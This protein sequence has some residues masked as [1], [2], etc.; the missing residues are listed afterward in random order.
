MKYES[1]QKFLLWEGSGSSVSLQCSGDSKNATWTVL[2]EDVGDGR[3]VERFRVS[4]ILQR[5]DKINHNGRIYPKAILEREVRNYQRLVKERR[6]VG[7][8]VDPK[9]EVFTEHGWKKI[10]LV[11]VGEKVWTIN[12]ETKEKELQEVEIVTEKDF[13]GEMIR[14]RSFMLDMM[15][16]PGHK[17]IYQVDNSPDLT[18]ET[19]ENFYN[20]FNSK[21]LYQF[22]MTGSPLDRGYT[23]K[24]C[25]CPNVNPS[26]YKLEKVP[27]KG[28]VYCITTKNGTFGIRRSE[29]NAPFGH[30]TH[31]CDHPAD[32]L[33]VEW[34]TAS[35]FITEVYMEGDTVYGTIELLNNKH[36]EDMRKIF[37]QG[38]R[39]G[40]S[41]RGAGSVAY[42]DGASIVQD[43]FQLVCWD[44]VTDPS[45]PGAFMDTVVPNE[46]RRLSSNNKLLNEQ[47]EKTF[48]PITLTE[49]TELDNY[50]G[51]KDYR[52]QRAMTDVILL[53]DKKNNRRK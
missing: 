51:G 44:L 12:Q 20:T 1:L 22:G 7:E 29:S 26:S 28:K 32:R 15:M 37:E 36:G 21:R 6:S 31:N 49:S 25:I 14:L 19:A 45:T 41:S 13:D 16:T 34:K 5:A 30:W 33:I 47:I 48:R 17:M 18:I 38:V 11:E 52:I 8:C 35:H 4:G 43:D 27:Y 23:D 46:S 24:S 50:L 39:V 10:P 40:I 3:I 9:T 2:K 42:A 53:N